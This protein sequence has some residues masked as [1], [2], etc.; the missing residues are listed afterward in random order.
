MWNEPV[1]TS[2]ILDA[3]LL[4]LLVVGSC[5][6]LSGALAA[7]TI[8]CFEVNANVKAQQSH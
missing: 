5:T 1:S 2:L 3:G 7:P 8:L 4:S 6:I